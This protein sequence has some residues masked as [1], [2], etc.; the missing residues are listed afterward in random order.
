[1][2]IKKN[3]II[4][5]KW[6]IACTICDFSTKVTRHYDS[7]LT[8]RL[9]STDSGIRRCHCEVKETTKPRGKACWVSFQTTVHRLNCVYEV[10]NYR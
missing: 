5:V 10:E 1:M 2:L 4:P 6:L 3:K 9:L 8:T 7:P